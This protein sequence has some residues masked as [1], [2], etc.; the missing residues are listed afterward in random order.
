M[1]F[2]VSPLKG[3]VLTAA[4][5][6]SAHPAP[7]CRRHGIHKR[8][9]D[10]PRLASPINCITKALQVDCCI[11][12]TGNI[13]IGKIAGINPLQKN[14]EVMA[15]VR[16]YNGT[17]KIKITGVISVINKGLLLISS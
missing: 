16:I 13:F 1:C 11:L 10:I 5:P 6:S 12:D 3:V 8:R 15:N 14:C 17:V 2:T 7:S 4:W 9:A